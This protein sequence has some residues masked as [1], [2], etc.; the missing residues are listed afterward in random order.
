M[1]QVREIAK[2]KIKD[3]NTDS[4]DRL[5]ARFRLARSMGIEVME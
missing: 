1:D 4:F 2:V 5:R 3:L